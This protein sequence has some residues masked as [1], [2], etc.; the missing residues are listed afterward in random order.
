MIRAK[1][2]SP[3]EVIAAFLV[4][5]EWLNPTLNAYC[6]VTADRAQAAARQAEAAVLRGA[7]L[8]TLMN[9]CC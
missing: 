4:R 3:T 7:P 1:D 2:L 6:I 8:P 5:M 9:C